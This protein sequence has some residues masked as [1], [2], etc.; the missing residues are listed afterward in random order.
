VA[1]QKAPVE[2]NKLRS[3][4]TDMDCLSQSAFDEIASIAQL[5]L[6]W[7]ERPDGHR[8]VEVIASALNNIVFRAQNA[9]ECIGLEA[10]GVGCE[11]IDSESQAR[12][13]AAETNRSGVANV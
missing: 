12:R 10:E 2:L 4:I 8:N 6:A 13:M 3:A 5:S 1:N 9:A 7:L 11:F